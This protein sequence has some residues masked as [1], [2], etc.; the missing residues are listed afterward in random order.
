M[1][2]AEDL[3]RYRERRNYLQL[4]REKLSDKWFAALVSTDPESAY[5]IMGRFESWK[6]LLDFALAREALVELWAYSEQGMENARRIPATEI[7]DLR[8]QAHDQ[9]L[10]VTLSYR[11]PDSAQVVKYRVEFG[12]NAANV[13]LAAQQSYWKQR[14]LQRIAHQVLAARGPHGR[15]S[16][17]AQW[18]AMKQEVEEGG[19]SIRDMPVRPWNPSDLF[20]A[21]QFQVSAGNY[22]ERVVRFWRESE[23]TPRV[24]KEKDGRYVEVLTLQKA[25]E[26][27]KLEVRAFRV[28]GVSDEL[29]P[30]PSPLYGQ[31]AIELRVVNPAESD[32]RR[33]DVLE[34]G[35]PAAARQ[36]SVAEFSLVNA[37]LEKHRKEITLLR[38]K[39]NLFAEPV[40]AGL[41]IGCGL[42]GV[43]FPVG[44]AARLGYNA[45]I[46]PRLIPPVPTT[47]QMRELMRL[48]AAKEK[49]PELKTKPA[50]FLDQSDFKKLQRQA[51]RI[52]QAE[53]DEYLERIQDEDL[54]AMLRLAKMAHLD[55]EI[56]NL[57]NLLAGSAKV[58]GWSDEPGAQR[59]LL[60]SVYFS[61]NGEINLKNIIAVLAGGKAATPLSGVSLHDLARGAGE[62]INWLQYLDVT[63]DVRAVANTVSRLLH[64]DLADKEMKMP[65]PYATRMSDI[66]AYEIRIFGY[67]LF[68][69]YKRG[70]LKHDYAAYQ[71]DYAY[72]LIATK[73]VE[74]FKTRAEMEA[75]ILAGRMMPLGFVRVPDVKGGWKESN[76]AVFAHHIP[77][78]KYRGKTA[79][80]IYGLR[81]YAE[82]S[83]LA[84]RE[85]QRLKDFE[86]VLLQGGVLEQ[87]VE[88]E[89]RDQLSGLEF[90]PIIHVGTNASVRLYAPLLGNL[91]EWRRHL[92]HLE[93]NLPTSSFERESV[94]RVRRALEEQGIDVNP[95]DGDPLI[96][97]N[98]YSSSFLYRKRVDGNWRTFRLVS[99]PSPD[100]M[101][102]ELAK[103]R[104]GQKVEALRRQG[105]SPQ[106]HGIAL[107]NEARLVNGAYEL[108]PLVRDKEDGV[109]GAG[110]RAGPTAVDSLLQALNRLPVTDRAYIRL[111]DFASSLVDLDVDGDGQRSKVFVTLEFPVGSTVSRVVTN[112]LTGQ[113]EIHIYAGGRL[114][115]KVTARTILEADYDDRDTEVA[116]RTYW[117]RGTIMAPA[118]GDMLEETRTVEVWTRKLTAASDPYQPLL[119][120]IRANHI[121]G[122]VS[123]E[124]FGLFA[125][126][127]SSAN[128]QFV[129]SNRF[130]AYGVFAAATVW[131]NGKSDEEFQSDWSAKVLA[132][133]PGR[134]RFEIVSTVPADELAGM[135]D[136]RATGYKTVVIKR[137]LVKGTS[138]QQTF[139]NA[140]DGRCLSESWEDSL[141][142]GTVLKVQVDS[143]YRDNSWFGLVPCAT[144]KTA[145]G[146]RELLSTATLSYD[147]VKRQL[148]ALEQD[149]TGSSRTKIWDYRWDSPVSIE[150]A[151]RKTAIQFNREETN[152]TSSTVIAA[153]GEQ[154]AVA[155]GEFD[156]RSGRWRIRR[157]YWYRPGVT[158]R[159]VTETRSVYGTLISS[160]T[161]GLFL[162]QPVYDSGGI[163]RSNRV[164]L[165]DPASG[166][167]DVPHRVEDEYDWQEG[168]RRARVQTYINGRPYDVFRI[169][170]D[171]LGRTIEDGERDYPGLSVATRLTYDGDSDRVRR[172]EELLNGAVRTVRDPQHEQLQGDGRWMLPVIVTP[173]WG[174]VSTQ[175]FILGDPLARPVQTSIEDGDTMLVRE[176]FPG[177]TVA[178]VAELV[179]PD[180]RPVE[181]FITTINSGTSAGIPYDSVAKY[182]LSFWGAAGL[183]SQEAMARGSDVTLFTDVNEERVFFDTRQT[184][185]APWYSQD[186]HRLSGVDAV[187]GGTR[188]TNVLA[189]YRSRIQEGPT[190]ASSLQIEKVDVRGL[191]F[192]QLARKSLDRSGHL[193]EESVSRLPITGERCYAEETAFDRDGTT[194]AR[195]KPEYQ[196]GWFFEA[197]DPTTGGRLLVFTNGP[198]PAGRRGFRVNHTAFPDTITS[199]EGTVF[200]STDESEAAGFRDYFLRHVHNLRFLER[201]PHTPGVV[202]CWSAWTRTDF[203]PDG[204]HLLDLEIIFDAQGRTRVARAVKTTSSDTHGTR[205][206][207]LVTP[208]PAE[209]L[210]AR[211]CGP[212][213]QRLPLETQGRKDFSGSDFLYLYVAGAPD[214]QVVVTDDAGR[215]VRVRKG[216]SDFKRAEISPWKI[217]PRHVRWLPDDIEPRQGTEL[218][219]PEWL[220]EAGGLIP[221]SVH[222]LVRAGLDI[223]QVRSFELVFSNATRLHLSLSPVYALNRG[224]PFVP[225]DDWREF[226]YAEFSH[227]SGMRTFLRS[228]RARKERDTYA[229]QRMDALVEFN[230]M[231][232]ATA[233]ARGRLALFPHLFWLDSSDL[234]L[235]RPLYALSGSDGHFLEY[236]RMLRPGDAHLYVSPETFEAP[237]L[238]VYRPGVLSDELYPGIVGYGQDYRLTT[239]GARSDRLIGS[240]EATLRRRIESNPF[241]V[242]GER[243][244][245]TLRRNPP[246]FEEVRRTNYLRFQQADTRAREISRQPTA[247]AT[248]VA[249]R[250][251]PWASAVLEPASISV[252]WEKLGLELLRRH[253]NTNYPTGL[254]PTAPDTV[255]EPFVDT[256]KEA[257]L[258]ILAVRL[259]NLA[260]AGE[261]LS[262]YRDNSRGGEKPLLA[263]YDARAGTA[264]QADVLSERPRQSE[265]TAEAQLA[266]AD[267]AFYYGFETSEAKWLSF[268]RNLLGLTLRQFRPGPTAELRGIAEHLVQPTRHMFAKKFW[269]DAS[270]YSLASNSRA[271]LLLKRLTPVVDARFGDPEWA[272][273]LARARDELEAFLRLQVLPEVE[274]TGV[275]PSGVFEIQDLEH[276]SS[277]FAVQRW[278]RAED[279]LWFLE[280]AA[281]MGLPRESCRRWLDNLA[282][283]HGV[284]VGSLWGLDWRLALLRPDAISPELTARFLR[285]ANL[286][287]HRPAQAFAAQNLNSMRR[288]DVF[289]RAVTAGPRDHALSTGAG[290]TVR[291]WT[292]R[293][294]WPP[295]ITIFRDLRE[296]DN[297]GWNLAKA[298]PELKTTYPQEPWPEKHTDLTMFVS[299]AASIYGCVLASAFF[300]WGFRALRR[301]Q[302]PEEVV[303]T[304]VPQP[305]MERAEERWAKRV[306]GL[307]SPVGAEHWRYSNAPVE[308]N[309]L[310]QFRAIYKLILEWRRVENAWSENDER[311]VESA[312]DAWLNGADEF[313]VVIGLYMRTVI[314]AGAKDGFPR[315]DI[316]SE[317]E[318]SN[319]I[320]ARLTLYFSEH[321]WSLS[322]AVRDWQKAGG[323]PGSRDL[324]TQTLEAMGIRKRLF[325]FDARR[326][327][328]YPADPQAM[329]LL[330]VQD[331]SKNLADILKEA[332][333]RMDIPYEQ[334]IS[335]IAG[336]KEFKQREK[337]FPVHPYLIEFAKEIPHFALMT[338]GAIVAYN[339]R[340]GD[341]PIVGYLKSLVT[342][343]ALSSQSLLWGLPLLSGLVL[344]VMA[345]FLRVYRFE[346]AIR[347]EKAGFLLDASFTSLFVKRHEVE[348]KSRRGMWR[349]PDA[350]ERA[351][352]FL[353]MI[354]WGGLAWTLLRLETPSFGTFLVVKGMFAM[355]AVTEMASVLFPL[356]TSWISM[357]LQDSAARRPW[358]AAANRLNITATRPASA[359][360]LSIKYHLQPSMPTGTRW[361][362]AQAVVFYF[363]LAGSFFFGA[364][365][366]CQ[367][368]FPLW[369]TDTYLRGAD[370][371]LV[372][373]GLVFGLTMILLR[374]G[375]FLLFS[376]VASILSAFPVLSFAGLI[377]FG[378]FLF[379]FLGPKMGLD[380]QAWLPAFWGIAGLALGL[381][382]FWKPISERLR[383]RVQ[384]RREKRQRQAVATTARAGDKPNPRLGIVY[385]SGDDLSALKLTPDL[386]MS[387]WTLLR[388][389]LDSRT[390]PLLHELAG[391]PDDETLRGWFQE[392]YDAENQAGVTLW[393]PMQLSATG[394]T[395]SGSAAGCAPELGVTI[396]VADEAQRQKLIAA[397]HIR[398]WLVCMMST[399]GHSQDTAINL[400]DI[401]LRLERDGLGKD[402]VF[403][404]IQN[405]YDNNTNNRPSQTAYD[406]G[407]LLHR[408]KLARLLCAVA[409]GAKAFCIQDWTP[410]GFKAG[411]LTG[412]DLVYEESLRLTTLLLLDRNATV[413]DIDS[414]M[415]DLR[416][417][418]SDPNLIIVIPG[419][420]T[421]NTLTPL[422]QASQL[423]EEGHRSFL[424]GLLSLLGGGASEAIG[425]GW[426]NLLACFYGRVQRA[427]LSVQGRKRPLTSRMKRGTSFADRTEGLIGFGPHAVGI[428][429]DIWAVVQAMNNALGLG[430]RPR[431]TLSRAIWHKIRETWSHAEW[432]ASFP[433]WAGGYFQMVH[434]PLM[435]QI[436]DFGPQSV[437]ARDIRSNS[438]RN[439][440]SAPIALTSIL[441][442]PLA[443]IFDVSPFVQT[444][445][446]LWNCGFVLNQVLTLHALNTYLESSG[447]YRIPALLGAAVMAAV[448]WTLPGLER[449]GPGLILLG[450]LAGGFFVGLSRWLATRVRDLILFG[451]QLVL[452]TLAQTVRLSLEFIVSGTSAED[453]KHV[454]TGFRASAGPREDRPLDPFPNFINLRT[455]IWG[456]G[457]ASMVLCLFALTN[458]DM[459]NVLLLLPS[460]LF[461]VSAV[462]GPFL[463]GPVQGRPLGLWALLPRAL[464]WFAA[465]L[466]YTVVS[467]SVS[468][469]SSGGWLALA[470]FVL[471]FGVVIGRTLRYA[472]F[473]ARVRRLR[474]RLLRLLEAGGV[475]EPALG[476][477]AGVVLQL[478]SGNL[479]KLATELERRGVAIQFQKP[480]LD[481]AASHVAPLVRKPMLDLDRGLLTCNRWAIEWSRA[482]VL[483]LLVLLWFFLVPVPGLTVFTAFIQPER[484]RFTLALGNIL[485]VLGWSLVI[486]LLAAWVGRLIQWFDWGP[487]RR[488]G[489]RRQSKTVFT[490]LKELP[491]HVT[492]AEAAGAFA[493]LTDS[494]TYF[495]QRSFGYARRSLDQ[496][497]RILNSGFGHPREHHR[498]G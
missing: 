117:N 109:F 333:L 287:D 250:R 30:V 422:G 63:V 69:Y 308:E 115:Q 62:P 216:E 128:D 415:L 321:L 359:L 5:E 427:L 337:P 347:R 436:Y 322:A 269:P 187:V 201:N 344:A 281:A 121:T 94:G 317:N 447:F 380:P 402:T 194:L 310:V 323:S 233:G 453:A 173:Q 351:G 60:N 86:R 318:D 339:Q 198:P 485:W 87:L 38:S 332:S 340:I 215:T 7:A 227:S 232:V 446:V 244:I 96:G 328:D 221:I 278:T 101:Q 195:F 119:A 290:F 19:L 172:A 78:G 56:T 441:L 360:W 40:F 155:A 218:L 169:S 286:L 48:V 83:R 304:L 122:L 248:L 297:P 461:S 493:C 131:D 226:S 8:R 24:L 435:Q 79:I 320:W 376:S 291:P 412:M 483:A 388:D 279:W 341:S 334:L 449:F 492:A 170:V 262:F 313:A 378:Q 188:R 70:L 230:G 263:S 50:R 4:L 319:H 102:R 77:R 266:M 134:A 452:H 431:F 420:G 245:Q 135:T 174:L 133:A 299:I 148:T 300:W 104:E 154:L 325:S 373:G 217:Y 335:V 49:I 314:K 68:I 125:L 316:L 419:R 243:L 176:W 401:A 384:L 440:L 374:Y 448:S 256:V 199:F 437:F 11:D 414:L 249:S 389:R 52:T 355:L 252:D 190:N 353:R 393:H 428:S 342:S 22:L 106:G 158:N 303:E 418:M 112:D 424:R 197:L 242:G 274:R 66:A 368:I 432:L 27:Q 251:V 41:N 16:A 200:G 25:G 488:H 433:R 65:F 191:F 324:I 391:E 253:S 477:L 295:S 354:G 326:V 270:R 163:E 405:K 185:K 399:A 413:H 237:R 416:E 473:P 138:R 394:Q 315:T 474:A 395:G 203:R 235:A 26:Q 162:S 129:V 363:V 411:G 254:I 257:D 225:D 403:Y 366:L 35:E 288:E 457:L 36:A 261:L 123:R 417:A 467:I 258:I 98:R 456:F 331:P 469:G 398:R 228:D 145:G 466:F 92:R 348:P 114:V 400:V 118:K 381:G 178:R 160:Q 95:E 32:P 490:R 153:T 223:R 375:L 468:Q 20:V 430:Y 165:L 229:G 460:L 464:G 151:G 471:V 156:P 89:D 90:E 146:G 386:L 6:G 462:A 21:V 88:A 137:D 445:V 365:Y 271:Y 367:Q 330:I 219:A 84:Q 208:P 390:T 1:S 377:A 470:L 111:R 54:L 161:G 277:A 346:A 177:T 17:L 336:Y 282:R 494:Q 434:D 171:E 45:V 159:V 268:G 489:L 463:A 496:A 211:D 307:Q 42:A 349:D 429:E 231:P 487:T 482:F 298:K 224:G 309:F 124:T 143:E 181:R 236:Y 74:H 182:R 265:A 370:A 37:Y 484:Y 80:I 280:A 127:V 362:L 450:F 285:V 222:D 410:F 64:R 379:A 175:T 343:L 110:V 205:I 345:H 358:A 141:G 9:P 67:P 302:R 293:L 264:M 240:V 57:L 392:L 267:A 212:G 81:A 382:L 329:D 357:W 99:I 255:A 164:I 259:G 409:P 59:D 39:F 44:E 275:V 465:L 85:Y 75:E 479:S 276:G 404:L 306:L 397:W 352:W 260:L 113:V 272:G 183:A 327:F 97:V 423:V 47:K 189:L 371:K 15:F 292:N 426:G 139:D 294:A 184:F 167:F 180:G 103:A 100:E 93:W 204:S 55:A 497:E 444:L 383:H 136:A 364:G 144:R 192:L 305:V 33:W 72:G 246:D 476:P 284:Q 193:L 408:N 491:A 209:S 312:G 425:T 475:K 361:G 120:K 301:R 385:M 29:E 179:K 289:P 76:L 140:V 166:S 43:P 58:S 152:Q 105:V 234:D 71:E 73:I 3:A 53:L 247:A 213:Q 421:T 13:A 196:P 498:D 369:F 495:D 91:L 14:E 372:L 407:E 207:Y 149:Y 132:P 46:T 10:F 438:G 311:L 28:R 338:L 481:F 356:V 486:V 116:T 387:R 214:S 455:V 31:D 61:V 12:F 296:L 150:S 18:E 108:G 2:K 238:E 459:L 202:D 206:A 147:A 23:I 107:I 283:V 130:N 241:K 439:F 51:K 478:S 210:K 458:L 350:Y 157:T 472:I 454:N 186:M 273:E 443:I 442:M 142:G 82:Q 396:P 126:S 239:A 168:R 480:I 34:F 220:T 406:R 451:P